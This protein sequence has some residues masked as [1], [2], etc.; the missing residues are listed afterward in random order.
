MV[1]FAAGGA[2]IRDRATFGTQIAAYEIVN[3]ALSALLGRLLPL[4]EILA[5]SAVLII[6]RFG[7]AATA[8]L[9]TM[10]ALAV[11]RNLAR[12]RTELVCGC[13]GSGGRHTISWWHVIGDLS[14][15]ALGIA[16][17]ISDV[18]PTVPSVVL[19]VSVLACVAVVWS[20]LQAVRPVG[21]HIPVE[22]G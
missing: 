7:G 13:F 19:G 1:L 22:E 9:F 16:T 18:R 14:L 15:A 17:A 8:L 11:G 21:S 2:K 4:G 6:P 12:R 5:A 3:E 20:V 10:F